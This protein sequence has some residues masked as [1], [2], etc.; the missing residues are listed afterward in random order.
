M[1]VT[2]WGVVTI[3]ERTFCFFV[4][5]FVN[6]F[7]VSVFFVSVFLRSVPVLSIFSALQVNSAA[8]HIVSFTDN[9]RKAGNA[10][11]LEKAFSGAGLKRV[12]F[13]ST[14]KLSKKK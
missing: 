14:P 6:V 12:R 4:C 8:T 3:K 7:F 5:I 2:N 11:I 1:E 13:A 9:F 10:Q